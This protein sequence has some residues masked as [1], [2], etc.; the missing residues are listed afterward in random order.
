LSALGRDKRAD[1]LT[2]MLVLVAIG[3]SLLGISWAEAWIAG[4][5]GV[6]VIV[7]GGRSF[8]E[9][10]DILMDRVSD[11]GIQ[12]ELRAIAAEVPGVI[13]AGCVRVHPL[14]TTWAVELEISVDGDATVAEGHKLAHEVEERI[15]Q[16]RPDRTGPSARE[17]GLRAG[18]LDERR[19]SR[20]AQR[21]S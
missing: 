4:G 21:A 12:D 9:G 7:L 17:S 2:S 18:R 20:R 15:T 10:L 14:G 5:I 19:H 6:Y 16:A 11:E 8:R 3:C 1:S 13:K